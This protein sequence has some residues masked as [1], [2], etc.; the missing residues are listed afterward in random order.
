MM[1]HSGWN[2]N[3]ETLPKKSISREST[4]RVIAVFSTSLGL[5]VCHIAITTSPTSRSVVR[6]L[7]APYWYNYTKMP[8]LKQCGKLKKERK[9]FILILLFKRGRYEANL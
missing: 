6:T 1:K 4:S 3:M 7:I 8:P 9:N 2:S 5:F